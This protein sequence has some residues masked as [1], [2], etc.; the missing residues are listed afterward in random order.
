MGISA[1]HISKHWIQKLIRV[2]VLTLIVFT[3]M[4]SIQFQMLPISCNI[5]LGL[6]GLCWFAYKQLLLPKE[7]TAMFSKSDL[8]IV[9][10]SGAVILVCLLSIVLNA[11]FDFAFIRLQVLTLITFCGAYFIGEILKK[12]EGRITFERIV[13]YVTLA[14]LL[15]M[16]LTI[17]LFFKPDSMAFVQSVLR[18][19]DLTLET[20]ERLEGFR[21]MGF[22]TSFFSSGY[23]H[24]FI[25]IAIAAVIREN[26]ISANRLL[27]YM[28]AFLIITA[29][30]TMSA[31][32]TLAGAGLGG[33]IMIRSVLKNGKKSILILMSLAALGV[34]IA[35]ARLSADIIERI[36]NLLH[37]GFELF[38]NLFTD[39]QLRTNSTDVMYTMYIFPDNLKTWLIGDGYFLDPYQKE[40]GY[41][42]MGTDI[43]YCRMLFLFGVIGTL[44]FLA[45]EFYVLHRI[46]K[47][48]GTPR[49]FLVTV[50]I[51]FL[52]INL[53]GFADLAPYAM[54]FYCCKNLTI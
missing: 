39:H 27:F 22:G 45:Y 21:L 8:G 41:Y 52:V 10:A 13:F 44:T 16:V 11:T 54:L 46:Y 28:I 34:G 15:Q 33:L 2:A 38:F 48:Q 29:V 24:S 47:R 14:A 50:A 42:Y 32:T 6:L 26:K 4:Y 12:T 37:F 20:M 49:A 53:K 31:R 30:S 36:V 9:I 40:L 35:I 3:Y 19:Q 51:L 23:I 1:I 18:F 25:L 43:G 17:L 7:Q 5:I